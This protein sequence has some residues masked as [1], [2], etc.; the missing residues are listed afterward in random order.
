MR[1]NERTE[2]RAARTYEGGRGVRARS[3]HEELARAVASCFLF[4]DTFYEKGSSL[5]DR[6][7][8]LCKKVPL[9]DLSNLAITARE[10]WKLRGVPLYI[11][12]QMLEQLKGKRHPSRDIVSVTIAEVCKRPDQLGE[13]IAMYWANGKRPLAAQLKKGLRRAFEKFDDYQLAKWKDAD[14]KVKLRDVMFLVHPKPTSNIS[15]QY[16]LLAANKMVPPDTW[17][18]HLSEAKTQDQ[19]Q[20]VWER[21]IGMKRLPD[22]ALL[23]NL[24]NM[25]SVGVHEPLIADALRRARFT[26]VLPHRFLAA[27]RFAPALA[28][29][30]SDAMLRAC[31]PQKP[32]LPGK[33][34]LLVD[35]SVSM[36]DPIS[37]KSK[38]SR[39]NAAAALAVLA[40]ERGETVNVYTFS[41]KCVRI[42]AWRGLPLVDGIHQ[43]Q[44]HGGTNLRDALLMLKREEPQVDR[45]IVITDEQYDHPKFS[46][47][48][49][50]YYADEIA[51]L[52]PIAPWGTYNYIMN[53]APYEVGLN[54]D[55]GW[56]RF[57]G[58][59]DRL[60]D[61]MEIEEDQYAYQR[62]F[63][64]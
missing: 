20:A 32:T 33:T 17:E 39:L 11:C 23:M 59:S 40:R 15:H 57:N 52:K 54:E 1:V 13:L 61:W 2:T 30:I 4:E 37:A 49:R 56:T 44:A 43:S 58:Y 19:K 9:E 18:V 10:E 51:R 46:S 25:L 35:V 31:A 27:A 7:A 8:A 28:P 45:I 3:A 14:K 48:V 21:L 34:L 26:N 16:T 6:I 24:R 41:D 38:M 64:R 63:M 62:C 60:L 42:A 50:Q 53:V 12:L 55:E 29:V 36:N 5:A 22:M 47:W